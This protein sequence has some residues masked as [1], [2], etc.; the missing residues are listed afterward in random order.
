[1]VFDL[2]YCFYYPFEMDRAR[3]M[4]FL[5]LQRKIKIDVVPSKFEQNRL[6]K[7]WDIAQNVRGKKKARVMQCGDLG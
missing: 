1:M 4:Q 7:S 2:S 6:S 5:P 3:K